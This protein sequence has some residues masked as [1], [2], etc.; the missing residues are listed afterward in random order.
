MV[1]IL[2][3]NF[4]EQKLVKKALESF[5]ALGS[6]TSARIMAKHSIHKLAK[7]GSLAPRTVTSL[8][9]ELSQMTL[10]TDARR[11]VQE[12][13]RRLKDMGT[14]RGRRHAMGLPVRGQRTRTQTA[15][16]NKLNR[17]ERRG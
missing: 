11:L 16:A 5:Y 3:V 10:E 8:T 15:T 13:I 14:Y 2:G 17:V 7:V 4:G 12:N 1:F 6:T 9:A